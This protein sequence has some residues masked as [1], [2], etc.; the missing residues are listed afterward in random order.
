MRLAR[1]QLT[2]NLFQPPG[3]TTTS[4][5]PSALNS[6]RQY[7]TTTADVLP[8]DVRSSSSTN[9][10]DYLVPD[11]FTTT[12][13]VSNS[14]TH[15]PTTTSAG[16]AEM[17]T[18]TTTAATTT[19]THYFNRSDDGFDSPDQSSFISVSSTDD[20]EQQQQQQ[21]MQ[22]LQSPLQ[23]QEENVFACRNSARKVNYTSIY[24]IYMITVHWAVLGFGFRKQ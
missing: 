17:N 23:K 8:V 5:Q 1:R 10:P 19:T 2:R 7:S 24:C 4:A 22:Q 18:F 9:A 20:A 16:V 13:T 12:S 6:P 21:R 15:S 11:P 3:S 14:S